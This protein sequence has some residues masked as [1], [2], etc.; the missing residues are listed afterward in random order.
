MGISQNQAAKQWGVAKGTISK[1]LK[2]RSIS[3]ARKPDGS[4]DIDPAEFERWYRSEYRKRSETVH[5]DRKETPGNPPRNPQENPALEAEIEGLREQI[6]LLKSERDDLR[7][8]LDAEA[9]ERRKLT[10]L[11]TDDREKAAQE[12]AGRGGGFWASLLGRRT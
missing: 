6:A 9:G 3:A 1:A 7:R 2:N 11:L 8:R 4:Y 5:G 12:P 10:A